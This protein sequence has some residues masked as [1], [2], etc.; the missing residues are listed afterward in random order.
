[1]SKFT[2]S[3]EMQQYK[4]IKPWWEIVLEPFIIALFEC[5]TEEARREF[6]RKCELP[7][8]DVLDDNDRLRLILQNSPRL[9]NDVNVNLENASAWLVR[10]ESE[11]HQNA[12][13][14]F[15]DAVE[16]AAGAL[17]VVQKDI[18]AL[19]KNGKWYNRRLLQCRRHT[20]PAFNVR[21]ESLPDPTPVADEL[22]RIV[23]MGQTNFQFATIWEHRRTREVLIGGFRTLGEGIENLGRLIQASVADLRESIASDLAGV[24]EEQIAVRKTIE[25]QKTN[26]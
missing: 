24:V 20:F 26:T 11:Y 14:P 21:L 5:F 10:A 17:D 23:R 16:N 4:L 19:A 6:N 3:G 18:R 13:A 22:R 1:M 25:K 15:W 2:V 12:F 9:A 7:F 8:P